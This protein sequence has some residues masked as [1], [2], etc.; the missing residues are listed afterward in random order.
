MTKSEKYS[1]EGRRRFLR[2]A[3]AGVIAVPIFGLLGSRQAHAAEKLD[4]N[5]SQ[6]KALSYVHDA[7]EASGNAAFQEGANCANC[8][9]WTGGSKEW[10]G[11]NI[12]PGKL[13]N[14]N[15]WCAAW[16]KAG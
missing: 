8:V 11:C 2:G 14:A 13:V 12:F 1:S 3:T 16:A 15:G 6:A 4:P 7:S 9:Q 10:G 5:S